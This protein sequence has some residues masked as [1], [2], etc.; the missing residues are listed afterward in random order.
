MEL[1]KMQF[2]IGFI[3]S[4]TT[5]SILTLIPVWQ[6]IIIPG[7]LSGMINDKV[8]NAVL[9]GGLGIITS[10]TIYAIFGMLSKNLYTI[11]DIFGALIFGPGFGW[12]LLILILLFGFIFGI[13]GGAIGN[14]IRNLMLKE[15]SQR[16]K[17]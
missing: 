5:S 12:I 1:E 13:L 6:L 11:L 9:S 14:L 7:I 3:F 17:K 2:L 8:R 16:E 15:R 4:L 10:W